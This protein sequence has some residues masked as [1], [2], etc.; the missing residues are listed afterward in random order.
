MCVY[1]GE[2]VWVSIN[3]FMLSTEIEIRFSRL[4]NAITGLIFGA[5]CYLSLD[6]AFLGNIRID[7]KPIW[8]W[9]AFGISGFTALFTLK[10]A[11][12]PNLIFAADSRGLRIGRGVLFN[13][14]RHIRWNEL[15]RIEEGIIRILIQRVNMTNSLKLHKELPAMRLVFDESTDLGRLGYGQAHPDQKS[16]YLIA[17]KL[18]RRPLPDTIALLREMKERYAKH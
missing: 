18:F 17:A 8:L 6:A 10:N 11:I 16:N 3:S 5:V 7:M 13:R 9:V 2:Y 14:V 1:I 12:S 4:G 15:V